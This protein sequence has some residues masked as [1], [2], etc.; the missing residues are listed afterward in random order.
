MPRS[1]DAT[2]QAAAWNGAANRLTARAFGANIRPISMGATSELFSGEG[3]NSPMTQPRQFRLL[4]SAY[5][6]GAIGGLFLSLQL[7]VEELF[8]DFEVLSQ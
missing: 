7:S 6:A 2:A 4:R 5:R 3:F 8:P 1:A